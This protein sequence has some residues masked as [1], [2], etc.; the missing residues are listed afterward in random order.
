MSTGKKHSLAV[1]QGI[2][3]E[4]LA[5]VAGT[6]ERIE[7]C[8]S[9]RRGKAEVGDIEI[10]A[11]SDGMA[12]HER[13]NDLVLMG[14][15]EKAAY[16]E[17]E[18][19]RW[20]DKYRGVMYRDV[21]VEFF[22]TDAHSWGYQTWLRTGPAE[23][24]NY[25]MDWMKR[26]RSAIRFIGGCGWIV[27]YVDGVP[28]PVQRVSLPDEGTVFRA[29]GIKYV[30]PWDRGEAVYRNLGGKPMNREQLMKL[31]TDEPLVVGKPKQMKLF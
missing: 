23:G 7:V 17:S 18:T 27:E 16:G 4:V 15:M 14:T 9:I 1:A 19:Q 2:A 29:L 8:G 11:I 24:N 12:L 25:I 6:T 22:L 20:G 3:E 13:L 21:K 28:N 31:A 30:P 10:V 26:G 5:L